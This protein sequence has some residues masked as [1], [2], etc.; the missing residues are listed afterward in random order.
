MT[1][2][3]RGVTVKLKGIQGWVI[4]DFQNKEGG[5][6]VCEKS[7]DKNGNTILAGLS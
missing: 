3:P 4:C 7:A 1:Y 2:E 6:L 5:V